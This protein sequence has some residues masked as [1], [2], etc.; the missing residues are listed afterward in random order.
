MRSD[1]AAAREFAIQFADRGEGLGIGSVPFVVMPCVIRL[2]GE[3]E[4]RFWKIE[5]ALTNCSPARLV[6]ASAA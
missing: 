3:A 6:A 4:A 1:F 5:P 2:G